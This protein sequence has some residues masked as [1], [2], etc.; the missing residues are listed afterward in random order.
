MSRLW[1]RVI[2][3]H[4]IEKQTDMPCAWGDEMETLTEICKSFDIPRPIWLNKHDNEYRDFRRTAFTRE[5]FVEE[6]GFDK[7]E[8]EYLDDNG[9]KRKSAD[10]RNAF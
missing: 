10:P 4:R 1:A 2:K 7:L 5:H 8:I 6:V 9:K 3:N